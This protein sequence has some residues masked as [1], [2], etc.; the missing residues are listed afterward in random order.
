MRL[1]AI[2]TALDACSVGVVADDRLVLRSEDVGRGHAERLMGMIRE[3]TAEAGLSLTDLDRLAVTVGP[4]SF[5]GVRVGI[6]AARALALVNGTPTVGIPTL[7]V[8]AEEARRLMPGRP[9]LAVIA[10]GRGEVYGALY[11]ADG[12]ALRQ[13]GAASPQVFAAMVAE[14][15]VLAGS[16]ADLVIAALPMDV[17]PEVAHRRA[18]PSIEILCA[19]AATLPASSTPPSPLY[20]R[21]PD[22]KPQ[23]NAAVARR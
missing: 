3:A 16:G 9:V 8:H 23:A 22:A 13:P 10:A 17:R 4:G 6:A 20:L 14:D 2:D 19:L 1:L 5:A 12:S 18:S 11:A 21:P 15:T 7:A